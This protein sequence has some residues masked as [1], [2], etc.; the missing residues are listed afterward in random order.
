MNPQSEKF[1]YELR[2]L[3][4]SYGIALAVT[5]PHR[6][7]SEAPPLGD[8]VL[9]KLQKGEKELYCNHIEDRIEG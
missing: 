3:C 8:I 6:D 7:K 2:R 1:I 4:Q 5:E 9:W